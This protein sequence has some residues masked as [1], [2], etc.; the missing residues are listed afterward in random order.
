MRDGDPPVREERGLNPSHC[1]TSRQNRSVAVAAGGGTVTRPERKRR[2]ARSVALMRHVDKESHDRWSR[3]PD[4]VDAQSVVVAG[5][6]S[7]SRFVE[8]QRGVQHPTCA[9]G[10]TV[11]LPDEHIVDALGRLVGSSGEIV[12]RVPG[13]ATAVMDDRPGVLE[14]RAAPF[15]DRLGGEEPDLI[16]HR[17]GVEVPAQDR[18]HRGGRIACASNGVVDEQHLADAVGG[19]RRQRLEVGAVDVESGGANMHQLERHAGRQRRGSHRQVCGTLLVAAD[20]QAHHFDRVERPSTEDRRSEPQR[21]VSPDRSRVGEP[22][23]AE[24]PVPVAR[25]VLG[26]PTARVRVTIVLPDLLKAHDISVQLVEP[27]DDLAPTF[28]PSSADQRIDVEL[29]DP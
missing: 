12:C 3:G 14:V 9:V 15:D 7:G 10:A 1:P 22:E 6:G 25:S 8:H 28:G 16:R 23:P 11:C 24:L 20:R 4:D 2:V 21:R 27:R 5:E 18:R 13:G 17:L 29:H 19:L 26:D